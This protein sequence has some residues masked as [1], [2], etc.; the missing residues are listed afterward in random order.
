MNPFSLRGKTILITG[1]SSGIGR[2]IAVLC[3]K[4]EAKVIITGRNSDR[5]N[6]TYLRLN[7][8]GN[9]QFSL[10]LA[11]ENE[12]NKL[13]S[14]LP[15]LDGVVNSAGIVKPLLLKFTEDS[16]INELMRINTIVPIILTKKL[17]QNN[18]INK[19]ASLVFIS[20]ING[21]CCS[22]I[23]SSIYAA[24]K[25]A[26]NGFVKAIALEIAPMGTRANCINPGMI[27]TNLF[28]N[29]PIGEDNLDQDKM[30][31]PLKRYGKPEEVANAAVFLLSDATLWITGSNILIDGGFTLQ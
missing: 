29:S 11:R 5:L 3:S 25:S 6:E 15:K 14:D 12:V 2:E 10:D 31:Y 4:M 8:N 23:G 27:E 28:Q 13:I 21:N 22:S 24:S 17:L 18:K 19:G 9:L 16:D 20:S 7:G 1:A 30:R 26:L